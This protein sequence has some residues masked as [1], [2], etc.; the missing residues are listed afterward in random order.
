M[1]FNFILIVV[2]KVEVALGMVR[3]YTKKAI[4]NLLYVFESSEAGDDAS[5]ILD[6]DFSSMLGDMLDES[7]K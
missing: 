6:Q 4:E 3:I 5:S 2:F 1:G 7:F